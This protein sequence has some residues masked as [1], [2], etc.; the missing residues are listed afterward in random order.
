MRKQTT[1]RRPVCD[2][3]GSDN[4]LI[5]KNTDI[6][7][8]EVFDVIWCITCE[9]GKTDF[10][11]AKTLQ[12]YYP[13][14]YYGQTDRRFVGIV[15]ALVRL[16]RE[17]RAR[18][19]MKWHSGQTKRI[20]DC[21]CGRGIMLAF[22]RNHDW[23]CVGTEFSEESSQYARG[24]GLDVVIPSRNKD[25][26]E[27]VQGT[28]GIIT[29]WHVLEHLSQPVHAI[30]QF[31]GL[32]EPSGLLVLEVPNFSSFQAKLSREHWIYT[33]C[34]RHLLHFSPRSLARLLSHSGFDVRTTNT[35][36]LEYGVF[37]LL[38]SLLNIFCPYKNLVFY[39]LRNESGR[40]HRLLTSLS[41]ILSLFMTIVLFAPLLLISALMEG[42]LSLFNKGGGYNDCGTKAS[43]LVKSQGCS[44]LM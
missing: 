20:L 2:F 14:T 21:G 16:S 5:V 3:C 17:R 8:N 1:V 33:E 4:L 15:E 22:L 44:C 40:P 34:P 30:K 25:P 24:M 31:N 7:S 42:V 9:L 27:L 28:F 18:D 19:V 37:G 35:F 39:L 41:A 10:K 29:V 13:V 23:S 32:L 12:S 11:S 38:Q 6:F 43:R 26:I 36:S